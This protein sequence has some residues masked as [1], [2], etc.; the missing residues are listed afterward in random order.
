MSEERG[1]VMEATTQFETFERDYEYPEEL[2]RGIRSDTGCTE[3]VR[4]LSATL[5]AT[6]PGL[7]LHRTRAFTEIFSKT[8][9]EPVEMRFAKA[10]CRTLEVMPAVIN[11]EELIVGNPSCGLKKM[12]ILPPVQATWAMNELDKLSNR[13]VDPV[14]MKPGQLE[15]AKE[16]LSYWLDKTGY[17]LVKQLC[18]PE[19]LRRIIGTG[20]ADTTGYFNIGG[21]HFT[22]PWELILEKG[23]SWYEERVRKELAALDYS[24]PEQMGKEHF[25]RALLLVIEGIKSFAAKHAE[26]ARELSGQEKDSKRKKELREIADV[27]DRVPYYGA[28]SF[29]EA[30]QSLWFVHML[31][32][33]EGTGP[34]YS[35]GRF[36]QFMH[37]YFK[38]DVERGVLAMEE[39]QELVECLCLKMNGNLF[40]CDSLTAVRTPA[41]PQH[42]TICIG[43]VTS[44]DRDASN[45][46]SYLVLEAVKSVR[47]VQPDIVLLCHQRET[48]YALKLKA[49][50]MVAL[51]L[52][53]PKLISTQTLKT[54]LMAVG[55]PL[56]EAR[57][58]WIRGCT[59]HYGPGGKQFGY[60]IA[61]RINLGIVVEAVLYNGRKRMPDQNMSGELV[62]VETGDPRQFKTFDEFM[63]AVKTQLSQQ[64]RDGH[65]AASYMDKIKVRHFP[66]LL[67]S[68]FT[69][70]CI[71]RGLWA[72]AG[73][74]KI[75][76]GPGLPVSGGIAT[77]ADSLAAVKKLVYEE[78]RISM[79]ELIRAIDANFEGYEPLRQMLIND[80]P[81]YGN[82]NDFVDELAREIWQFYCAEARRHIAHL[83]NK[84]EASSCHVTAYVTAGA[85]TWATP[86][87]RKAGESLS[88]HIGPSDQRDVKGPLAHIKSVT[89]LGLDSAFGSVHNMYFTNIDSRER[90]H[91][92]V[93]LIDLYHSFGGHHLQIN[94]QDKEVLIDAQKHPEKYPT[95]VVRVAGYMAN[96]V[97]LPKQLQDEIISRTSQII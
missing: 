52:G 2:Q 73:G 71:G 64:I 82:D 77:I 74:A 16:L 48:P 10:F 55:Y 70:D 6:R 32:H 83:G 7:C 4:K 44:E 49:A 50:E 57:I 19:L 61:S 33:V 60:P 75:N 8:E 80:A 40:L 84:N 78:R 94:C 51:G 27:L 35:I 66:L 45:E 79:D 53:M 1:P 86:D 93:N 88:N 67:Q 43:G 37:P 62:G 72:N 42:Q 46:L 85:S 30:V 5:R 96:F 90:L 22:P 68:L 81:K 24:N 36:D 69:E 59:E 14:Q 58:G 47:T 76:C 31:L 20:W 18:P 15:E 23:L 17:A 9:G 39:A 54:Q 29:R 56:E 11:E 38:S 89:K 63:A 28:R 21:C 92:L 95:L 26:T 41:F 34:S 91:Q 13:K 3:R 25:Y 87:G 12:S 97:E 65:I